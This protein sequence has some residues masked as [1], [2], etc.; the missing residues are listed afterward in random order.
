MV[1]HL[2]Q[3]GFSG[4]SGLGL[5]VCVSITSFMII[6]LS[7]DIFN[8]GTR[9]FM[10]AFVHVMCLCVYVNMVCQHVV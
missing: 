6:V 4:W 3:L 1:S 7:H 10:Y 5:T 8:C 9:V 2:H